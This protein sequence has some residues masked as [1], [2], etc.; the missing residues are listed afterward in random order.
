MRKALFSA[1]AGLA[2]LLTTAAPVAA[3]TFREEDVAAATYLGGL[4][5]FGGAYM[6]GI[7][8][9]IFISIAV[10]VAVMVWVYRDAKK[11]GVQNPE[12]WLLICLISGLLGLAIYYFAVRPDAI[13]AKGHHSSEK[14][15]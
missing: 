3:Q 15:D 1:V 4:S 10:Q 7:C 2:T 14:K 8:C 11:I 9:L 5:V 12:M 13:A 6:L